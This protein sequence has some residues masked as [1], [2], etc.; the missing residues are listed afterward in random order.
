MQI[1]SGKKQNQ[2]M[3]EAIMTSTM[4]FDEHIK[5]METLM[6]LKVNL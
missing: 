2:S 5:C 4:L 3:S 1:K 6:L